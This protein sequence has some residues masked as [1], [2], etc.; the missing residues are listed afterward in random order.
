MADDGKNIIIIKKIQG[1]GHG[2]HHGGAWKVAYADFVTAM[3]AFFLLMWLLGSVSEEKKK[4]IAE[5]FTPT[6]GLKDSQGIGFDG[7]LVPS[8][9]KEAQKSNNASNQAI[10][11]GAP[12]SGSTIDTQ[13]ES[14]NNM[15]EAEASNFLASES[16]INKLVQKDN[17]LKDV[18]DQ[19]LVDITPE[20]LRIRLLEKDDKPIFMPNSSELTKEAKMILSKMMPMI[21]FLPNYISIS[22]HTASPENRG[23]RDFLWQ[24]S[25]DRSNNIRKFMVS[26]VI[27]QAQIGRLK[28]MADKEPYDKNNPKSNKNVRVEIILL[29][30]SIMPYEGNKIGSPK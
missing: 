14:P 26:D 3:M 27:D 17:D 18:S 21:K 15:T 24:L 12:T 6:V 29:K 13:D 16:S 8:D 30:N 28:A 1:G 20:G 4:G 7:G 10:V 9:N 22:G 11:F 2:G 5:Y 25:S 19:I 23:D